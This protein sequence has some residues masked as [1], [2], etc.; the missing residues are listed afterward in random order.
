MSKRTLLEIVQYVLSAMEADNVNSISE[1][2]ES[3]AIARV[4]E[5]TFFELISQSDWPHLETTAQMQSVSD[6]TKPNFLEV[7][8]NIKYI[9]GLWYNDKQLKYMDPEKF[10]NFVNERD[11]SQDFIVESF[12]DTNVRLKVNNIDQPTY[13]TMFDDRYVITDSF[14]SDEG[15]TLVG[16]KSYAT[17]N[18]IPSFTQDDAFVP[19]LPTN[20]FSTYLAMVKR[21]AFLYFRREPSTKDERAAIAGWG[22]L[23]QNKSK[24]F[25]KESRINYGRRK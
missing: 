18:V 24:L 10:I 8:E 15:A 17:V 9:K 7:P 23:L 19:D 25:G 6:N 5:E 1:T 22:R 20:M 2:V 13:F 4:A 11:L 3:V 14:P 12:T 21:A 16:A